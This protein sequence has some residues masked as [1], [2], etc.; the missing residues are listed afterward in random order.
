[1]FFAEVLFTDEI[2]LAHA[3]RDMPLPN[4]SLHDDS[5]VLVGIYIGA[6]V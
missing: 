1:M 5:I 4:N 6:P 3:I 2:S